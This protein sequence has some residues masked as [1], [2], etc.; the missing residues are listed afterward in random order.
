ME[1]VPQTENSTTGQL[2][3]N[4]AKGLDDGDPIWVIMVPSGNRGKEKWSPAKSA[5]RYVLEKVANNL[6]TVSSFTEEHTPTGINDLK[7]M[8]IHIKPPPPTIFIL[9]WNQQWE[10]VG[11]GPLPAPFTV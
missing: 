6:K 3:S 2:Y 5:V 11:E 4:A 8:P 9:T 10:G 7:N 1:L